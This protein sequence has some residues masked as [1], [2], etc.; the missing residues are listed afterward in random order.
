MRRATPLVLSL[1][2]AAAPAG[3]QPSPPPRRQVTLDA[4]FLGG[5]VG[6]AVPRGRAH[7][8]VQVG[9]SG[10][11]LARMLAGGEHFTGDGDEVIELAHLAAF[12]RRSHG[13]RFTVD[14]GV[15]VSPFIHGN[16]LDDDPGFGIFGGLYAQPMVGTSRFRVGPRVMAGIFSEGSATTELGVQLAPLTGRVIF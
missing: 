8:G 6:Y 14:W 1:L 10:D 4:S 11:F 13:A 15:R 9:L 7:V 5:A 12:V 2:L 3:A 16:D